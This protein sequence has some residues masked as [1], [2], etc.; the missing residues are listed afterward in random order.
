[1]DMYCMAICSM[2][3][4][5]TILDIGVPHWWSIKIW[6]MLY[7]TSS[8]YHYHIYMVMDIRCMRRRI[9]TH[10][11][12]CCIYGTQVTKLFFFLAG[13]DWFE[14]PIPSLPFYPIFSLIQR[15][16]DTSPFFLGFFSFC[17]WFGHQD[18]PFF[19]GFKE[20]PENVHAQIFI[21]FWTFIPGLEKGSFFVKFVRGT[22]RISG[23]EWPYSYFLYF[24]RLFA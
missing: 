24:H 20:N 4:S 17:D 6:S 22:I 12:T 1:M 7:R 8:D 16:M 5:L 13:D 2:W 10:T 19:C 11:H 9:C 14:V 23:L 15:I 3:L 21:S 18:N